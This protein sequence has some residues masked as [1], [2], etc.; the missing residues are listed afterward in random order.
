MYIYIHNIL[1]MCISSI[2]VYTYKN[3]YMY[4]YMLYIYIYM[5]VIYVYPLIEATLIYKEASNGTC[6][7]PILTYRLEAPKGALDAN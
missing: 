1:Y 2:C 7:R 5:Y 6:R 4:I 3:T